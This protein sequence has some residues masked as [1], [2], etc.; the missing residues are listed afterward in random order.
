VSV[1][2]CGFAAVPPLDPDEQ[3]AKA[4]PAT[5][6]AASERLALRSDVLVCMNFSS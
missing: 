6:T 4:I 5:A 2:V 3:P 1:S